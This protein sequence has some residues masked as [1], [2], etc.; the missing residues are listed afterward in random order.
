MVKEL[1]HFIAGKRIAG[2]SGRFGDVYNPNTGEVQA[3]VAL[4]SRDELATAVADAAT[5]QPQWA[6]RNPQVRARVFQNFVALLNH[7]KEELATLLSSEHGKTVP[8]SLGDIQRGLEVCE[9]AT[10]IPQLLKGEY[11]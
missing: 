2:T 1:G 6:A 7:H 9:F 5:A 10:G 11:T 3:R 4:A 8:D